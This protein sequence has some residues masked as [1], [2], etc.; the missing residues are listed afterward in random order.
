MCIGVPCIQGRAMLGIGS[1]MRWNEGIGLALHGW[2]V[3]L[4]QASVHSWLASVCVA[5]GYCT[6]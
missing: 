5:G 2:Q 6:T 1:G 3:L 4:K